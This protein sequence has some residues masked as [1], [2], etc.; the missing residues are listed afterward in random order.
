M[1]WYNM[2]SNQLKPLD[3]Q[4]VIIQEGIKQLDPYNYTN[5]EYDWKKLKDNI[6]DDTIVNNRT[7]ITYPNVIERID[8]Y[9]D[10]SNKLYTNPVLF[11]AMVIMILYVNLKSNEKL[12]VY[13]A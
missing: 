7:I 5:F 13:Q 6:D 1:L 3:V 4:K 11:F 8:I 2:R 10:P 12:L 9:Q